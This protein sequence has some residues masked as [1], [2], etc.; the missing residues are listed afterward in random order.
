MGEKEKF[1]SAYWKKIVVNDRDYNS[2]QGFLFNACS[3]LS[4]LCT[5]ES[6]HSC[7][8]YLFD[9]VLKSNINDLI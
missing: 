6:V 9:K 4:S 3:F 8:S 5:I 1:K 7:F 2:N